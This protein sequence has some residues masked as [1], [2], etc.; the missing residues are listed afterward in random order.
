LRAGGHVRHL[1]GDVVDADRLLAA[2][3]MDLEHRLILAG[4]LELD[5]VAVVLRAEALLEAERSKER[6][7]LLEPN[8]RSAR[9]GRSW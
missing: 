4:Q 2:H 9:C 3:A 1:E 7:V 5:R 6:D 8:S